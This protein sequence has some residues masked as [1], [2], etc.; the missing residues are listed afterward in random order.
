MAKAALVLPHSNII[1]DSE[2]VFSI[3]GNV[4]TQFPSVLKQ[5][6]VCPI[7]STKINKS[8]SPSEYKPNGIVLKA[9]K[10]AT[11]V[12]IKGVAAVR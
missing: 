9:A 10:S 1:A 7:L 2:Q 3:V 12:S 4:C 8:G 11:T 6:T 5:E